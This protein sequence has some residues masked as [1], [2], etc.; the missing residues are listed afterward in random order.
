MTDKLVVTPPPAPAAGPN[1]AALAQ[2]FD[3]KQAAAAKDAAG[4]N[5]PPAVPAEKPAKPEWVPEKF[6][7]AEKGEVKTED[8]AKSYGE[9]EKKAS[10]KKPADAPAA[11]KDGEAATADADAAKQVAEAAGVDFAALDTEYQTDGKLSDESYAKLAEKGIPRDRVDAY[12]AGVQAQSASLMKAAHDAAGGAEQFAAVQAWA[13]ENANP[14][15]LQAYNDLVQTGDPAK[16]AMAVQAITAK[17]AE[18]EGRPPSRMVD[19]SGNGSVPGE[20]YESRAQ[21]TADMRNPLYKSDP[22]FRAK[23]AAKLSRSEIM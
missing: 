20:R 12:I 17:H 23:V 1:D 16:I 9:L 22:A 6:W 11:K 10:G 19:G 15:D 21:M 3:D 5:P 2:K 18:A 8:M 7:D 14:A 13:A 4:A